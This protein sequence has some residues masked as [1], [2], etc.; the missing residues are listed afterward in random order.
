MED[1]N[2]KNIIV[3]DFVEKQKKKDEE[4]RKKKDAIIYGNIIK[5]VDYLIPTNQWPID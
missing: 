3:V 4:E 5:R 1:E 2:D